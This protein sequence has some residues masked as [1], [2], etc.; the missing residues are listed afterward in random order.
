[1]RRPEHAL[2][3]ACVRF[4]RLQWP[5]LARLYIAVPNG[6]PLGRASAAQFI[7]EGLTKGAPDTLLLVPSGPW[8]GLAIEFKVEEVTYRGGRKEVRR[9]YQTPEQKEWQALAEGQ[10]YRYEVVRTFEQFQTLMRDYLC[11]Q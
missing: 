4:F 3:S 2:Q 7:L 1:M 10:G 8:H 9:T 6:V 5:R 11:G